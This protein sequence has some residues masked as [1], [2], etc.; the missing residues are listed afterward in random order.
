MGVNHG[1]SERGPIAYRRILRWVFVAAT[2]AGRA[3]GILTDAL[4][5]TSYAISTF[6]AGDIMITAIRDELPHR[7]GQRTGVF[8]LSVI[9]GTL[10]ILTMQYWRSV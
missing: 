6:I 5:S 1:I 3:A 8:V 4:H 9:V 10:A 7:D 2:L